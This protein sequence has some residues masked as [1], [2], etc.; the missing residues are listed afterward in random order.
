MLIFGDNVDTEASGP[1]WANAST[2]GRSYSEVL[3]EDLPPNIEFPY[4][5]TLPQMEQP[6]TNN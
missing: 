3:R 6:S 4:S 1:W 2:S 5:A